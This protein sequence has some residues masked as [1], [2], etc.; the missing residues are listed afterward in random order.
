M[1]FFLCLLIKPTYWPAPCE[2]VFVCVCVRVREARLSN[3]SCFC[4]CVWVWVCLSTCCTYV[5]NNCCPVARWGDDGA[6]AWFAAVLQRWEAFWCSFVRSSRAWPN[7]AASEPGPGRAGRPPVQLSFMGATSQQTWA[8]HTCVP[9]SLSLSV[10]LFLCLIKVYSV[11]WG[12]VAS[13]QFARREIV[14]E[15][16]KN[17]LAKQ[18]GK[19]SANWMGMDSAECDHVR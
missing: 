19:G 1:F 17:K 16:V 12:N 2:C 14:W 13:R 6:Y 15:K 8:V 5:N 9:L 3:R 11:N 7:G 18:I 4:C 10:P